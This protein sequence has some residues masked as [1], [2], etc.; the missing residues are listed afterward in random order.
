MIQTIFA[1]NS[2]YCAKQHSNSLMRYIIHF[3]ESRNRSEMT[4]DVTE[5]AEG[6][7][8]IG[9]LFLMNKQKSMKKQREVVLHLQALMPHP[10]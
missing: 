5:K 10:K 9:C 6:M 8:P 7:K 1:V 3:K 4:L 2:A